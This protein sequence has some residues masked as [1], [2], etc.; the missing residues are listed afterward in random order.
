MRVRT[1]ARLNPRVRCNAT[2][3]K[4]LPPSPDLQKR[5]AA[6]SETTGKCPQSPAAQPTSDPAKLGQ[7][8]PA[9]NPKECV[10][11]RQATGNERSVLLAHSKIRP[12]IPEFSWRREAQGYE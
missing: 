6:A 7:F 2:D 4:L 1:R 12:R 11:Q 9:E 8:S 10:R 5:T 3:R